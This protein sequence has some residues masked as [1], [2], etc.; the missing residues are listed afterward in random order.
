MPA[1]QPTPQELKA[2][3]ANYRKQAEDKKLPQAVRNQ[4]LDTA[5]E[6]EAKASG[7]RMAKGGDVKKK[8]AAKKTTGVAIVIGVG[9]PKTAM[10]K[11][12]MAKKGK[13]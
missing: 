7:V 4:F 12:G 6:L 3:A 5:N 9:K 10:A 11:G 2:K 1:A 8:A 13:C